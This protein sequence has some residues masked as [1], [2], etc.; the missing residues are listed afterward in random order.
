MSVCVNSSIHERQCFVLLHTA[1]TQ[2]GCSFHLLAAAKLGGGGGQAMER[3]TDGRPMSCTCDSFN[4]F[5]FLPV[6]LKHKVT[7]NMGD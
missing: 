7:C 6:L 3:E 5:F 1:L 4:F 2:Q